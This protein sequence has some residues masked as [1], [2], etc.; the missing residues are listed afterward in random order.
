MERVNQEFPSFILAFQVNE[1]LL[2]TPM[3][4]FGELSSYARCLLYIIVPI[5][6]THFR[7]FHR[8][9]VSPQFLISAP[10]TPRMLDGGPPSHL[11][12]FV[13]PQSSKNFA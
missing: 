13:T 7:G 6:M 11:G 5:L 8:V 10:R 3:L 9:I 2:F 12:A 1:I 4:C